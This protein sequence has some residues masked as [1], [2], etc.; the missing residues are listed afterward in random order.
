MLV[1]KKLR[2]KKCGKLIKLWV[3]QGLSD[4]GLEVLSECR[5]C[6]GTGD[7][8]RENERRKKYGKSGL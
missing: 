2:C 1:N 5:A 7:V 8:I 6:G 3:P 4:I